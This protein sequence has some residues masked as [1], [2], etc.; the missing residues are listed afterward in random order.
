MKEEQLEKLR[1]LNE[2]MIAHCSFDAQSHDIA[3]SVG[4]RIHDICNTSSNIAATNGPKMQKGMGAVR[5][6][7][8]RDVATSRFKT[9]CKH[10]GLV[11]QRVQLCRNDNGGGKGSQYLGGGDTRGEERV[12]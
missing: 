8:K 7:S 9:P 10:E 1:Y 6:C 12:G 4:Y 2:R 3:H 5:H 11:E